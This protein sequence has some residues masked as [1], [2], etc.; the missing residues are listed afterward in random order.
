MPALSNNLYNI[1]FS[2]IDDNETIKYINLPKKLVNNEHDNISNKIVKIFYCLLLEPVAFII[3]LIP[4]S[5]VSPIL[6]IFYI[7]HDI[8]TF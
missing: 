5:G 4:T 3:N 6:N 7:K 8:K 1:L 2:S